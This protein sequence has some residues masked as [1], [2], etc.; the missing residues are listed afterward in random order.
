MKRFLALLLCI[1]LL[2]CGCATDP[3]AYVPTGD[4]LSYGDDYT[5]P[6]HTPVTEEKQQ[7]LTL[8]YYKELSLNPYQCGDYTNRALFPL[9]Y[10]SLFV[11][12]RSYTAEPQL[13]SRYTVSADMT[14]YT[15]YAEPATF[16]DGAVLTAEDVEVS[17]Y[18][19]WKSQVYKGRF[20]HVTGIE[21][22][23]DGGVTVTL[24]TP[25]E[26]F[27][28]LLDV[29]IVKASQVADDRPL[30][31]GPYRMYTAF[32]K[33]SLRRRTNWWCSPKMSVTADTIYLFAAQ[34]ESHIRDQFEFYDLSM[35]YA[36]PGS[37]RYAD[38][39]CD[40]ELWEYENGIFLYMATCANSTVFQNDTLRSALTYAIN[41]DLLVK[42]FYRGFASSAT[43]PASP[44]SPYYDQTLAQR[45]GYDPEKFRQA[46]LDSGMEGSQIVFLVN[47]GDSLRLR[48]ARNIAG[49]LREGGLQVVMK[50]LSGTAYTD[51]IKNRQFDVYLG[52]TRLSANMDL[53]AFF[54]TY[55]ELSWG[56]VND[57]GA[58]S[59]C[60]Q[61][62]ENHGNYFNLHKMVMDNGL[63]CP[64]LFRSYAIYASR[65]VIS[66]L[67]PARDNVFYY[68][69]GKTLAD[70]RQ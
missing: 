68:S 54:E 66:D 7:D 58:Y 62:L 37:D 22:T 13:C 36:D 48:V 18:T 2:L 65:G 17:L 41:R 21:R 33:D 59:L 70:V 55:G 52:Q 61:A 31:T 15:F 32:E 4:G 63:L 64:V 60:L 67:N 51:A 56:G 8:P 39:R 50:E 29:P 28:M 26:N 5:G 43:L 19:A 23:E 34:S 47:A 11:L 35:A 44:Y 10:Q 69:L 46:V 12:N 40:Y 57:L 49:M 42:E 45:Y 1:V 27:T 9:I 3:G 6:Q 30:G 16:S 53:S 24:D 20:V 14:R 25:Y 38:Y